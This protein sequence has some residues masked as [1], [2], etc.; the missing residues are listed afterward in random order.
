MYLQKTL[1]RRYTLSVIGLS[2][3]GLAAG[4][5]STEGKSGGSQVETPPE[6]PYLNASDG[7][8]LASIGHQLAARAGSAAV[9]SIHQWALPQGASIATLS[10]LAADTASLLVPSAVPD[11]FY[12]RNRA[13][14]HVLIDAL[15]SYSR[16]SCEGPAAASQPDCSV[17][18]LEQKWRQVSA[19]HDTSQQ[20]YG[21]FHKDSLA[22]TDGLLY[23]Q[24]VQLLAA[25]R[26]AL[27]NEMHTLDVLRG[28]APSVVAASR[29]LQCNEAERHRLHLGE[30]QRT[31]DGV[32]ASMFSDAYVVEL[33]EDYCNDTPEPCPVGVGYKACFSGPDGEACG[34]AVGVLDQGQWAAL[35]DQDL[36]TQ[37]TTLRDKAYAAVHGDRRVLLFS[38]AFDANLRRFE[39]VGACEAS[40]RREQLPTDD[41]KQPNC[42]KGGGESV[43]L[44]DNLSADGNTRYQ[45]VWRPDGKLV[46]HEIANGKVST[47]WAG[48]AVETPQ[49]SL[50]WQP[51]GELSV[52]HDNVVRWA[53]TA[54]HAG[55][56]LNLSREG[57]LTIQD[58]RDTVI[59]QP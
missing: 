28:V 6:A 7:K 46:S 18:S 26:L 9:G 48:G 47:V 8:T 54:S 12:E 3:L 36:L 59:W 23:A 13:D 14:L 4:G 50:C 11:P 51:G 16:Q 1:I 39:R 2:L 30:L 35:T 55:Q 15:D 33:P 21:R 24:H 40:L 29:T 27:L 38:P 43:V 20:L 10:D 22:G 44:L 19:L 57:L 34:P 41:D 17:E 37:A 5:C 56:T 53:A 49:A 25:A 58:E 31:Y 32:I 45:L 52:V 42:V